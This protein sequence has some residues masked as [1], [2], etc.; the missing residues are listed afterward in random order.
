MWAIL[1]ILIGVLI[2]VLHR[3]H[4]RK[5]GPEKQAGEII[6]HMKDI[7][8]TVHEFR[9]VELSQYPELD[10]DFYN[11]MTKCFEENGFTWVGDY[12]DTTMRKKMPNQR[13]CLRTLR[14]H[15]GYIVVAVYDIKMKG[16]MRLLQ[17]IGFLPKDLR[18]IDLETEFRNGTF[19]ATSTATMAKITTPPSIASV[20]FPQKTHPEELIE[21]HLKV[22]RNWME[23]DSG[24]QPIPL[25]SEQAIF[26]SQ[27]RMQILKNE[28]R[29]R[30]GWITDEEIRTIAGE[31]LTYAGE[32]VIEEL[33]KLRPVP[34]SE[35]Q[36]EIS[37]K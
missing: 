32:I 18:T 34:E 5:F 2:I 19:L 25:L 10:H 28:Y 1:I 24:F 37:Q 23:S 21:A 30:S 9:R 7:Y 6:D 12:E 22:L 31:K 8:S 33:H 14:S 17:I 26:D 13:A 35:N 15:D 20:F 16:L 36:Y 27:E 11:F 3:I 29:R 4:N